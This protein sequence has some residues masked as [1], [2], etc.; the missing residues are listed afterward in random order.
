[1]K[2]SWD[3]RSRKAR[4]ASRRTGWISDTH[5][6]GGRAPAATGQSEKTRGGLRWPQALASRHPALSRAAGRAEPVG[7]GLCWR[8][9]WWTAG[10]V[11]TPRSG[12]RRPRDFRAE[13][14]LRAGALPGRGE[15]RDRRRE[16]WPR[17]QRSPP[18]SR[19][20]GGRCFARGINECRTPSM[21]TTIARDM[22]DFPLLMD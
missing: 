6:R 8:R 16:G 18:W 7:T 1:M 13:N 20:S 5:R 21:A 9:N 4:T 12:T 10:I 19:A 3:R 11:S 17:R 14:S 22:P 15:G 2:R